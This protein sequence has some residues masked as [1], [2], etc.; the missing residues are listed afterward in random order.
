MPRMRSTILSTRSSARSGRTRKMVSYSRSMVPLACCGAPP[1]PCVSIC[2]IASL[3]GKSPSHLAAPVVLVRCRR[4]SFHERRDRRVRGERDQLFER[5]LLRG[6]ELRQHP[7]RS[8]PLLGRPAHSEAQ[9]QRLS[10]P[11]VLPDAPQAVV[12]RVSASLLHLDTT[13]LQIDLVVHHQNP[14]RRHPPESCRL[15]HR[16]AAQVHE[17]LREQDCNLSRLAHQRVP[18]VTLAELR[19]QLPRRFCGD[20]K[21]D[22]VAGAVPLSPRGVEPDAAARRARLCAPCIRG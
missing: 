5:L 19:A 15:S 13:E 17:R 11:E 12:P 2:C 7:V 22:V 6:R 14:F 20:A 4:R 21:A 10:G 3:M 8:F 18:A 9:P 16:L 1:L